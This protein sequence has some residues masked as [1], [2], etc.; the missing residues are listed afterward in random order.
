MIMLYF[1]NRWGAPAF[2][3]FPHF[4]HADPSYRESVV[5]MQPNE[6]KHQMFIDI[7]PVSY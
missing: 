3:S 4:F 2:I 5:G 6:S 7:E 1:I